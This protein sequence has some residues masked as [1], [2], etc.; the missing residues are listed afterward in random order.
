MPGVVIQG[1]HKSHKRI[2]I[3]NCCVI[4]LEKQI[5]KNFEPGD[6]IG[7]TF[8]GDQVAFIF[9]GIFV[10]VCNAVLIVD[11]IFV[12]DTTSYLPLCDIASVEKGISL[13]QHVSPITIA[14]DEE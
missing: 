3:C 9:V 7:V 8:I 11:D 6:T 5:R 4:G 12:E 14:L 13:D 1:G 10:D 2:P